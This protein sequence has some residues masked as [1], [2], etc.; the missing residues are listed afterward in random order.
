[1][2]TL[3]RF[4]IAAL[5]VVSAL[6]VVSAQDE[7]VYIAPDNT[8]GSLVINVEAGT[9]VANEDET[10]TLTLEQTADFA[11]WVVVMPTIQNALYL[12][13]QLA[14]DWAFDNE[15]ITAEAQLVLEEGVTMSLL[16]SGITL[17]DGTVAYTAE[18]TGTTGIEE[19]K[20]G[21]LLPE[22]FDAAS[23]VITIDET[24]ASNLVSAHLDRVASTRNGNIPC[25]PVVSC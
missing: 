24:F 12:T 15:N 13:E 23:L 14:Q 11:S 9:L 2:K 18:L 17:E 16:L 22:S 8:L 4:F 7:N 5:M 6:A 21:L 3:T 1:M 20:S 19:G 10:Y 25:F